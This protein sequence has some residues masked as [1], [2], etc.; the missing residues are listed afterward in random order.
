M[1][2]LHQPGR[3]VTLIP[4]ED[5]ERTVCGV[6]YKIPDGKHQEVIDHLD[7]REK[8][9]YERRFVTFYPLEES[10][11]PDPIE[12]IVIYVATKENDSYAGHRSDL[13]DIASQILEACGPSG[14]NIEYVY[15]LAEAMRH[16]FPDHKDEHLFELEKLVRD[17]E[18]RRYSG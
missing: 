12:N 18:G 15:R 5:E 11:K 9:G 2:F 3:V 6:A 14:P 8:N 16:L 17:K 7:F 1:F 13:N 10:V 4:C